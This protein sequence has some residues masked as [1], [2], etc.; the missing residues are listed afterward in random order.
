MAGLKLITPP[1]TEPVTLGEIKD[2]LRIDQDDASLN[3]T[4]EPL[5]TAAREW[6]EGYQ[7]RVYITQTLELALDAWPCTAWIELPRPPLKNV[8]SLVYTDNEGTA[9]TWDP[10]NYVVDEYSFV[11]K[12]VCSIGWPSVRLAKVNGV[13]V[14]YVAGYGAATDVPKKIKQAITLLVSHWFEHGECD[15]PPAVYSLLNIDRVVPV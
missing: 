2:Q 3:A 9:T 15:P 1:A 12:L 6:C 5:I 10:A 7:N 14:R 4:L 8:T 11:A 13:K